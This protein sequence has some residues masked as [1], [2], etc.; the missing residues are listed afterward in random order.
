MRALLDVNVLVALFDP[1]HIAHVAAQEWLEAN[2][3]VGWASCPL[4][5]N[6]CLR[7]LTHSRYSHPKPPGQV[8]AKLEI[9]KSSG[10]HAFWP[11]DVS[12][13]DAQVFDR[14]RLRGHQQVTDVYLLAL[15][16][17]HGGRLVTFDRGIQREVV[18]RS[19][20]EHLVT[21]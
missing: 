16:V 6:G 13:T 7:L 5:E 4:P 12:I 21:L 20:T 14:S 11:D 17:A 18:A 1:Q 2:L 15:A 3:A 10:Y 8:L 19:G 9:A